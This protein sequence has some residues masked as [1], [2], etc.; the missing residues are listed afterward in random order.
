[1][2]YVWLLYNFGFSM[3][4]W[5]RTIIAKS[6]LVTYL[7]GVLWLPFDKFYFV[8]VRNSFG[9]ISISCQ[10]WGRDI[11]IQ[12]QFWFLIDWCVCVRLCG[13]DVRY[14]SANI[15]NSAIHPSGVGKWVV[16]HVIRY[17]D[18]RMKA[19]HGWLGHT[20]PYGSTTAGPKSVTRAMGTAN[21]RRVRDYVL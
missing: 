19:Y 21:L 6:P 5:R 14:R 12:N 16:I 13:P 20:T 18:Y 4:F 10:I 15:A 11:W 17:M 3:C 1:M 2:S 8:L 9:Q 7:H